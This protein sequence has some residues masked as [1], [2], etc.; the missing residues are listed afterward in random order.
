MFDNWALK[1]MI[2]YPFR[3]PITI[4]LFTHQFYT[5]LLLDIFFYFIRIFVYFI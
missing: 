1:W 4:R 5:L 3:R 2:K